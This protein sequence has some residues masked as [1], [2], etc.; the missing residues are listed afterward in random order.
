MSDKPPGPK[1]DDFSPTPI[2]LDLEPAPAPAVLPTPS[3]LEPPPAPPAAQP[4]APP[5]EPPAAPPADPPAP[6]IP[7]ITLDDLFAAPKPD[8]PP[9]A[10]PPVAEPPEAGDVPALLRRQLKDQK[11]EWADIVAAKESALQAAEDRN[12]SLQQEAALANPLLDES[13]VAAQGGMEAEI[14]RIA[15]S[16]GSPAAARKFLENARLYADE[17]SKLGDIYEEG[18][19]LRHE[20]FKQKLKDDLGPNS[21][22]ILRNMPKVDEMRQAMDTAVQ[23]ANSVSIDTQRDRANKAYSDSAKLFNSA[24]TSTLSFSDELQGLDPYAAQNVVA[25]MIENVP[26]FGDISTTLLEN[27]KQSLIP[28]KPIAPE[29]SQ[30]LSGEER[31]MKEQDRYQVFQQNFT[32]IQKL[33]PLAFHSMQLV[34]ILTRSLTASK[35]ETARLVAAD[36]APGPA[37][38]EPPTPALAPNGPP[39]RAGEEFRPITKQELLGE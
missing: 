17:Y 8:E 13:V 35:A 9:V 1:H 2:V 37:H 15:K 4:A 19:D 3:A 22:E 6:E 29:D 20:D 18:Y 28:P 23:N 21:D 34:P 11:K 10:E 39:P 7:P 24:V 16:L 25:K 5:A 33:I 31:R 32:E 26:G 27:L 14:T 36:P 12:K 38:G 30:S